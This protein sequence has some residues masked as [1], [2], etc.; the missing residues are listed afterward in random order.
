MKEKVSSLR[1][2]YEVIGFH[3]FLEMEKLTETTR[4]VV[5][6]RFPSI[7]FGVLVIL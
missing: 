6:S 7:S 4:G 2:S 5:R 1:K 3:S